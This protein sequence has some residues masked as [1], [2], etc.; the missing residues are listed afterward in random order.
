MRGGVCLPLSLGLQQGNLCAHEGLGPSAN[1][2]A[3]LKMKSHPQGGNK[4]LQ[5]AKANSPLFS[6]LSPWPCKVG[7]CLL[8]VAGGV[9]FCS[10]STFQP[11]FHRH[12]VEFSRGLISPFLSERTARACRGAG[13]PQGEKALVQQGQERRCL[14]PLL[15]CLLS[16]G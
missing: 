3:T 7:G 6:F 13:R 11:I 5:S 14:Q 10:G 12:S 1:I 4:T 16:P 8:P 9:S 2:G 15:S